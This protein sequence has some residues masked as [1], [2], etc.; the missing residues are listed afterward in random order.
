MGPFFAS[1]DTSAVDGPFIT[2][3]NDDI[4]ELTMKILRSSGE[5]PLFRPDS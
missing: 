4:C 1:R 2:H 5:Y 3:A